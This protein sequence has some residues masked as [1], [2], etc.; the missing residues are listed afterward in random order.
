MAETDE[1]LL[2]EFYQDVLAAA[3][4]SGQLLADAFFEIFTDLLVEEGEID[5]AQRSYYIARGLKID[6]YGGNPTGSG[7]LTLIASETTGEPEQRTLTASEMDTAFKRLTTFLMK[8]L[9]GS[10]E[11]TLDDSL[12]AY[13]LVDLIRTRW[14]KD[15]QPKD[16]KIAKVKLLLITNKKLSTR[17]DGRDEAS[18]AGVPVV[19]SVW[20]GSRLATLLRGAGREEM[21]IDLAGEFGGAVPAL[22][23]YAPGAKLETYLLVLGGEQLARIYERWG[24]RLL[25]QNVRVYL[26]ARGKVNKGI[27]NTLDNAP[28][29]FLAYN[30]GVT[31]TAEAVTVKMTG[32]GLTIQDIRN[33]QIVNGGQTTASINAAMRNGVDLERVYVQVKLSVVAPED[34][35][36]LVPKIS[37]YANSQNK[38]SAADFF[39][40]HPFHVRIE[41]FSR[42][43][44]APATGGSFRQTKWFYERARGQY[45]DAKGRLSR[46]DRSKF[47]IEFPKSQVLTKTDL[48]KYLLVWEEQ[49]QVVSRGAQFAFER[50][51][52][53]VT[54]QWESDQSSFS[55]VYFRHSIA[56]AIVYRSLEKLVQR[57]SWYESG[58][59]ANIVAY[60]TALLAKD[61]RVAGRVFDYQRVWREQQL[62]Q[63]LL[64]AIEPVAKEVMLALTDP[65]RPIMN[66]TEWA[67]TEAFWTQVQDLQAEWA[68]VL[69]EFSV[70]VEESR[71]EAVEGKQDQK[72]LIGI[73]AQARVVQAPQGFWNDALEFGRARR[74]LSPR[75]ADILR[76]CASI[77]SKIPSDR[78]SEIALST[79]K[80]LQ[81][82]GFKETL[83]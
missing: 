62:D 67:K 8:A 34:V 11:A 36:A 41:E 24:P 37:E 55:E 9:D 7:N 10:L 54:K 71:Q 60:T 75:E 20:D 29:M 32:S 23:A 26:Q 76:I 50:F 65:N 22:K 53:I 40:N 38:V 5:D 33:L 1:D 25:E 17:I 51:S 80:R 70:S 39:S 72:I 46:S 58:Y 21:I 35:Q 57:A 28:E 13:G 52:A 69:P 14:P 81:E 82:E 43:V 42:R 48:A 44:F 15:G 66:V 30:N 68:D 4:A 6:G 79:L 47:E 77:P 2:T 73:E 19:H 83:D 45:A 27:R 18:V 3:D 64:T 49:P 56:K 63:D 16:G 12:P 59:R 78:Q 31:A 74:V 61:L